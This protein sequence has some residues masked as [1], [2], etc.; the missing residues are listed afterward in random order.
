MYPN[1]T[2]FGLHAAQ[3]TNVQGSNYNLNVHQ[4]L[5]TA[6]SLA[7]SGP[8]QEQQ[9]PQTA[10]PNTQSP[11]P[12]V[13]SVSGNYSSQLLCQGRGFPLFPG[14]HFVFNC[15][16]PNGAVLALPF[17]AHQAKLE[18]LEDVRHFVGKHAESWYKY[19]NKTKGRGVP[20]GSLYLVTG[21]EKAMSWG[22]ASFR[23]VLENSFQL[24]FEPTANADNGYNY[25]WKA[26]HC[27]SKHGPPV[28]G[29]P[30]NQTPLDQTIFIHAFAISVCEGIWE[31][32]FGSQYLPGRGLVDILGQD[33]QY[34]C[35]AWVSRIFVRVVCLFWSIISDAAPIP[36]IFHPS[37]MIHERILREVVLVCKAKV[38]ITHDDDWRDVFREDGL[39]TT[40]KNHSDLQQAIFDRFQVMEEEGTAFLMPRSYTT[41]VKNLATMTVADQHCPPA[42]EPLENPEPFSARATPKVS[43]VEHPDRDNIPKVNLYPSSPEDSCTQ[44]HPRNSSELS[45]SGEQAIFADAVWF[46]QP[47]DSSTSELSPLDENPFLPTEY[48]YSP[49]TSG[50]SSPID[51]WSPVSSFSGDIFPDDA[52]DDYWPHQQGLS[53]HS[54]PS[55]SPITSALD[56]VRLDERFSSVDQSVLLNGPPIVSCFRSSS[57]SVQDV[58]PA[59][60]WADGVGRGRSASFTA[61]S[62]TDTQFY[63]NDS[64]VQQVIPQYT[65]S[66][67]EVQNSVA[68]AEPTFSDSLGTGM[69]WGLENQGN[70]DATTGDNL[71]TTGHLVQG[72][73]YPSSEHSSADSLHNRPPASP[74]LLTVP[75]PQRRPERSRSH[76]HLSSLMPPKL[77]SGRGRGQHHTPLGIPNSRNV[78]NGSR[79]SSRDVSSHG[80]VLFN[81]VQTSASFSSSSPASSA[82]EDAEIGVD[83]VIVGRQHTFTTIR[84]RDELLAPISTLSRASRAPFSKARRSKVL[85]SLRDNSGQGVF[86]RVKTKPSS[87]TF[88]SPHGSEGSQQEFRV[89]QPVSVPTFKAEVAS[90]QIRQASNARRVNAA[91]FECPLETCSSTFTTRRN[92]LNHINSHNKYRPHRCMC[93]LSFTTQG[94]LNRHK[95]RCRK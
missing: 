29:T 42:D 11:Q 79:G 38:V 33:P 27:H 74:S 90:K 94:V 56:G 15:E 9:A 91:L 36:Q 57:L 46:I 77:D 87:S 65:Y 81:D 23:D 66:D 51:A 63:R 13:Y 92:L 82:F 19:V 84:G 39:G 22:M 89:A 2:Q 78:S 37:Q 5:P 95:K 43:E 41:V 20:N 58:S 7:V 68:D 35:A 88:L 4:M 6:S 16:G 34:F 55:L 1:A 14:G 3:L 10:A 49:S 69:S 47:S 59:E 67:T 21:W 31:K 32:L 70:G 62:T 30:I 71:T 80:A 48:R 44:L 86:K 75:G 25:R 50:R 85:S 93:G 45:S 72:R 54:S 24:S 53:V 83:G 26:P 76:S 52:S 12:A 28:E 18:N 61:S 40:G 60:I 73:R 64:P 8:Q 17:G